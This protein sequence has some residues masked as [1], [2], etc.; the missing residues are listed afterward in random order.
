MITKS[1]IRI[2]MLVNYLKNWPWCMYAIFLILMELDL[3]KFYSTSCH[4]LGF[5]KDN[6]K[7]MRVTCYDYSFLLLLKNH[8][9]RVSFV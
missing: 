7:P 1:M 3:S 6:G 9:R 8:I 2:I 4:V 5:Y